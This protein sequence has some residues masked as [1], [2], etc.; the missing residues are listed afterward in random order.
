MQAGFEVKVQRVN[1]SVT[2][3]SSCSK[4]TL[5]I[6]TRTKTDSIWR[7]ALRDHESEVRGQRSEVGGHAGSNGPGTEGRDR[8][9]GGPVGDGN[10]VRKRLE[11][12]HR[13]NLGMRED[14]GCVG[15]WALVVGV[16][17]R[18]AN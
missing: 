10:E 15:H 7:L 13:P 16:A 17:L 9:P 1:S 18:V 2:S 12:S 8:P 6:P 4:R 14:G 3:L 11:R 5:L